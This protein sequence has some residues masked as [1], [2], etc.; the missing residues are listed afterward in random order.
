MGTRLDQLTARELQVLKLVD[1]GRL[2]K[3]IA[4]DLMISHKTVEVHRSNIMKKMQVGSMA[5][6]VHLLAKHSVVVLAA[7]NGQ[8][9]LEVVSP[10]SR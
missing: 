1:S 2:T 7:N 6:L 5:E 4:R 8:S 3:E 9:T 10:V